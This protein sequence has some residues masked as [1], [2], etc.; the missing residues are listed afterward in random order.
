MG[1]LTDD[2][3]R[4]VRQQRM[5]FMATVCPDGS[6]NL[7]PK[8]TATVWDDDHLVFADL[9]SPVTIENLGHNP[10]CEINVVDTFLRKGYR[11]KGTAEVLTGGELFDQIHKAYAT[12]SH[13]IRRSGLPAER[14]VLMTVT[15]AAALV[16]PGYTPGKT[17][18]AMREEWTG[19]WA[20]VQKANS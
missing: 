7:S 11:F 4:V 14:Y 8:G 2:M 13:G 10:A 17:E 1:I 19:Y 20:E 6:P 16:S 9:G 15:K 5:G 18:E 12:G 3:K